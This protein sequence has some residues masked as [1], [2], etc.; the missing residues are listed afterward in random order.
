[1]INATNVK[2]AA[3]NANSAPAVYTYKECGEVDGQFFYR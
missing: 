2:Y 3:L 1:M